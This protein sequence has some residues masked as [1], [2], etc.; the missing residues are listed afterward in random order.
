MNLG[1]S[2]PTFLPWCGYFGLLNYV[3]EFVILD[4]VQFQKRS[5]QQR[6]QIK[7][8]NDKLFLTVPV[9]SKDK[10]NQKISEVKIDN[11]SN[12]IN[13]HKK[14]IEHSY[15]KSNFFSKYSN[16]LFKI[17][18]MRHENL[19]DFNMNLINY[20]CGVLK[21][22]TKILISSSLKIEGTK[23]DLIYNICKIRKCKNYISTRGSL[24]YLGNSESFSGSDVK[25][26]Y[27][28]YKNLVYGQINGNFIENLSI[29]D[30][31][32]NL[33]PESLNFI[34]K[35]FYIDENYG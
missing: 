24:D 32:F 2:Q 14:T 11:S 4:N 10:R 22:P 29:L 28:G 21:I 26:K 5:W 7:I 19:L 17:Y 9:Y 20:F 25:I 16:S 33:G 27:F 1:I 12:F 15:R 23:D 31:I 8:L 30:L 3:D 18:D 35:N 34:K 13:K 6:N